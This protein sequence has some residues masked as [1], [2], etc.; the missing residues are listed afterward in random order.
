MGD[1]AVR[2]RRF[3]EMH[4]AALWVQ[5]PVVLDRPGVKVLT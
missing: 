3:A 2:W 5:F 1:N 4:A